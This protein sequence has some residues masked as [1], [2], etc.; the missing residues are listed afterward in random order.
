MISVGAQD[1]LIK[2]D[3]TPSALGRA[4]AYA[5]E[6]QTNIVER[7][8]LANIGRIVSSTV[9]IGAAL[10]HLARE[11]NRLVPF[12]RL[13]I[14]KTDFE[15]LQV[16]DEF[17]WGVHINEWDDIPR[18]PMG[19]IR[20]PESIRNGV[21]GINSTQIAGD[22]LEAISSALSV[23]AGLLSGMYVPLISSGEV[24]GHYSDNS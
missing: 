16:V 12:D 2:G 9:D 15:N 7:D 4:I 19:G 6:R 5:V 18:H 8:A 17:V 13:V 20:S 22:S 1:C 23:R 11:A 3:L 21:G 14:S 24:F 10:Q